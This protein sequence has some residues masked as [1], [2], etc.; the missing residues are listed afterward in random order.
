M[1]LKK[2]LNKIMSRLFVVSF[3][4]FVQFSI[5]VFCLVFLSVSQQAVYFTFRIL[6]LLVVVWIVS[7]WDNPSFKLPWVIMILALPVV[8]GIFYLLWGNKRLP[9]KMKRRLTEF[10]DNTLSK[11]KVDSGCEIG[12]EAQDRQLSA[13][14]NYLKYT[15]GFPAWENTAS[16]FFSLGDEKLPRLLEEL[17]KAEKFILLEYFIISPGL[18]WDSVLAVLQNRLRAGVEVKIL[19]DDIGCIATLPPRYDEYLRSLGFEVTVFNPYEPHLNMSMNYRDH[20][21]ICVI[22][23]NVGFCGGANLADEYINAL[24][25]FG[26]W[27][28]TAV[29]LKGDGVWNLTLMFLTLWEF[30]NPDV[31]IQYGRYVPTVQCRSDGFVQPFGDSP[32]DNINVAETL[33][34]QAINRATDYLYLTT[35]Y[36]VLDNEM[37]TALSTAAQSGVDVRL[38]L[39]GVPDKWYVHLISRSYYSQLIG[40]GVRIY[41]YQ[42]GFM[43][44]KELV[45]DDKIAIVGTTNLDF[46]SF[47]LHFECGVGFYLSSMTQ[48]VKRDVLDTLEVCREI[49]SADTAK[50]PLWQRLIAGVFRLFAPLV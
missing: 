40:D 12:L 49:T 21:K 33:Y 2:F 45:S 29:V 50:F 19:F 31:K 43:H 36:L 16:E 32:L 37:I 8:G 46:R 22:D 13:M 39:P 42:P 44:A 26:H 23:G 7:K 34:L 27:K 5:V 9:H 30:S 18:M 3:A 35:P 47:Y 17:E 28:D 41:E 15:T 10:Y 24:P 11:I 38:I 6:S 1:S 48:K 20:R 14:S 25:R 4:I